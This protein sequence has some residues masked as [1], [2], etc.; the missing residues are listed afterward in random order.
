MKK[1]LILSLIFATQQIYGAATKLQNGKRIDLARFD[2]VCS[3][4]EKLQAE[5]PEILQEL[6][7]L[8]KETRSKTKCFITPELAEKLMLVLS[9]VADNEFVL[10]SNK[11]VI[12]PDV[13]HLIKAACKANGGSIEVRTPITKS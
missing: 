6:Y 12:Y 11:G 7:S 8:V 2:V 10:W 4:L 5:H 13:R 9:E 1:L 3:I